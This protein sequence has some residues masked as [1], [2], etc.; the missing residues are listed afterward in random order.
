MHRR[1]SS[2]RVVG[3]AAGARQGVEL[4]TF[5][6]SLIKCIMIEIFVPAQGILAAFAFEFE[7]AYMSLTTSDLI[8][9]QLTHHRHF[10]H[11][12]SQP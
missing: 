4:G 2:N 9:P 11:T 12:F 6:K 10:S 5:E 7:G 3:R 1:I 8:E